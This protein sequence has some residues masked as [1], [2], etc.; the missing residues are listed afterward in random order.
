[1]QGSAAPGSVP[2]VREA[3]IDWR[4]WGVILVVAAGLR[5]YGIGT[6]PLWLDEGYSWWDSRQSLGDLWSL[7]TQCDPLPPLYPALLKLWSAIAGDSPAALR[8]LGGIAGT[9]TT[10][11]VLFA[12]REISARVAWIAGVLAA[13]APFQIE[14]AHEARPYALLVLGAALVTFGTLRLLR[15]LREPVDVRPGWLALVAGSAIAL[16]TNNTSVLMV[17]AVGMMAVAL[18]VADPR[19]RSLRRPLL[20]AVG[21]IAL[22]W[23]PYVPVYLAQAHGIA[24][25]FWIPRPD[26]WRVGNELRFVVGLGSFGVL[27]VVSMLAVAGL[28]VCWRDGMR[29]EALFIAGLVVLPVMLNLVVSLTVKPIFI[30][31]ALIVIAPPFTIALAAALAAIGVKGLRVTVIAGFAAARLATAMPIYT[32]PDRKEQWD[33]IARHLVADGARDALVLLVPNELALPLAHALEEAEASV[34]MRGVPA[35]FPA[36]GRVARYPSG[37]CTPSVVGQDLSPLAEL[38]RTKRTVHVVTRKNNVYDPQESTQ[39]LLRSLGMKMTRSR[40]FQPGFLVVQTFS[41]P[42]KLDAPTHAA[43]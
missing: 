35:D 33:D 27:W 10:L 20:V 29:R 21:A 22:A 15:T 38:V 17:V 24:S 5:L 34:P 25:D 19:S 40:E 16:W 28:V 43:R 30:A 9:L 39:A 11:T 41:A 31:R 6:E 8:A 18:L 2:A 36:P 4:L 1:M 13:I 37:K 32:E 7:V 23:L 26:V 3:P 12:G 14:F 42:V